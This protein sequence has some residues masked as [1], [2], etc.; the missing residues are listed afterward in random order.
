[1]TRA[2][3]FFMRPAALLAALSLGLASRP[4]AAERKNP[5]AD[6]KIEDP[7]LNGAPLT[8]EQVLKLAGQE[9]IPLR[10]RKE[11]ILN[12]GIDFSLSPDQADKL[13]SAGAS[14]EILKAV[15]AKAKP[16]VAASPPAAPAKKEPMGTA[17]LT[18]APV[19]C[20]VSLDG[21]PLGPTKD[22]RL[23]LS[24][25][26]G[27]WV[28]DFSANGYIGHQS[29]VM[30]EADRTVPVSVVLEPNRATLEGFG[31]DLYFKPS[32]ETSCMKWLSPVA[33]SK[34]ART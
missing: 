14:D 5:P 6:K 30:V 31:A 11:A 19:E 25:R 10:R 20:E 7:F 2:I 24:K 8:F 16:V 32:L 29:T 17:V 21:K 26:P 33:N 3:S 18:C 13:K 27:N 9:A 34:P 4:A 1:M 15:K 23:E 22:G 28:I 12:R